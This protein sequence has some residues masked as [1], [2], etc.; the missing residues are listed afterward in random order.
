MKKYIGEGL[1]RSQAQELLSLELGCV[2]LLAHG[3]AQQPGSSWKPVLLGL[4]WKLYHI[5][6]IDH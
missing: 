6:V 3:C 1:G 5:G 4:L 2:A